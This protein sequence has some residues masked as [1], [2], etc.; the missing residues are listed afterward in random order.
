MR[1]VVIACMPGKLCKHVAGWENTHAGRA[2]QDLAPLRD[3]ARRL[4][5][6]AADV[7]AALAGAASVRE[8]LLL[9]PEAARMPVLRILAD[10][11]ADA[12]ARRCG[13]MDLRLALFDVDGVFL[14]DVLRPAPAGV[15]DDPEMFDDGD[16]APEASA[17]FDAADVGYRYFVDGP[18]AASPEEEA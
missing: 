10:A 2:A 7:H 18:D 16:D 4:L 6:N 8:S 11:A 14:L 15:A 1:A 13:G 9:L 12:L 3:A 5:P 17:G